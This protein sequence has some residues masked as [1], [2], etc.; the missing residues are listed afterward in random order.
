MVT[1]L[2]EK[3]LQKQR[4]IAT[5]N[6]LPVHKANRNHELENFANSQTVNTEPQNTK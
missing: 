3:I 4:L 2:F 6:F 5:W 1:T